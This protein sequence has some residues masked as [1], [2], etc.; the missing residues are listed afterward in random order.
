MIVWFNSK[1]QKEWP[2]NHSFTYFT[3]DNKEENVAD[4]LEGLRDFL[5]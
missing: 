3:T 1:K 5:D 4:G 2:F